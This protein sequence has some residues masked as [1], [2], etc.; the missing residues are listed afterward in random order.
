MTLAK[1]TLLKCIGNVDQIRN[2]ISQIDKSRQ[3]RMNDF[4]RFIVQQDHNVIEF[5]RVL[6]NNGL[7]D[8]LRFNNDDLRENIPVED[9]G[10]ISI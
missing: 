10:K 9:I 6:K 2:T 8:L 5:A 1:E 7:E 3:Q 4:L